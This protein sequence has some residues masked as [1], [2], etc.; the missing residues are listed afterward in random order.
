MKKKG[1]PLFRPSELVGK[2]S[3][4]WKEGG[5]DEGTIIFELKQDR[6]FEAD[7]KPTG[8]L[9]PGQVVSWGDGKWK[10]DG[11]RLVITMYRVGKRIL[12]KGIPI[13]E[14]T[15]KWIDKEVERFS[16]GEQILFT[17]GD[18]LQYQ[19]DKK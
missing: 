7:L 3:W 15:E 1:F 19:A 18:E 16:P 17:D 11:G 9:V 4:D 14:H 8:V 6:T 10:L 12:G 5:V 13:K 2:W